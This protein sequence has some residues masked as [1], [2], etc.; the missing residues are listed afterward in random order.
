MIKIAAR[1]VIRSDPAE[2]WLK[3]TVDISAETVCAI[4]HVWRT[5]LTPQSVLNTYTAQ[6]V[7]QNRN[8]KYLCKLIYVVSI[9]KR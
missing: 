9:W 7:A 2:I 6:R 4:H 3:V 8:N 1:V 5:I